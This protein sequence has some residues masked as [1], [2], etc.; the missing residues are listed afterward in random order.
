MKKKIL[1]LMTTNAMLMTLVA[2]NGSKN[3]PLGMLSDIMAKANQTEEQYK[4]GSY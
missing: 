2:C 1:N 3:S 4:N